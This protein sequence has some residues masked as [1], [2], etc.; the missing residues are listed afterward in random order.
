MRGRTIILVSHHVQLCTPGASYIVA[1]DNGRLLFE[2]DRES[3]ENSTIM[4]NLAHSKD[5]VVDDNAETEEVVLRPKY[6][7]PVSITAV[8]IP[9]G[10]LQT[11]IKKRI[12]RK[13]VE[14][15]K[16]AVGTIDRDV[17]KTYVKACG[18]VWYW[19]L[20]L[21]LVFLASLSPVFENGWI[22][23]VIATSRPPCTYVFI[24]P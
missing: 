6:S 3:F 22:R 18:S 10:V 5:T 23:C 20:F 16:R 15:E 24:L 4:Q 8:P 17:W 11:E 7:E 2:G 12:P 9:A 13:L 14:D 1:L 19:A 21:A